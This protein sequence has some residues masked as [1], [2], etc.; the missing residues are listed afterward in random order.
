M[1]HYLNKLK[2]KDYIL[3]LSSSLKQKYIV[4]Q[5]LLEMFEV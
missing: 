5:L 2:N 1:M 3:I 4:I